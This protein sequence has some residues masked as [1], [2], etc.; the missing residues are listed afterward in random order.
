MIRVLVADDHFFFRGCLVD[1]INGSGDARVV[2]ECADGSEVVPAVQKFAPN[3][4]LTDV[5]MP[6]VSGLDA[7]A[8]LQ[9]VGAPARVLMLT[10]DPAARSRATARAHGAAGYL[11]KG[12]DP[13]AVLD[14]IRRV[15]L[16]GTA[17]PEEGGRICLS[18]RPPQIPPV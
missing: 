6:N 3:V 14:A 5:R 13:E 18:Y 16:G 4:V 11:L 2:A 7:A 1:L 9:L 10:S 15:A 17:W 8:A 12:G